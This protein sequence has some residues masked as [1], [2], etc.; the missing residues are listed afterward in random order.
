LGLPESAVKIALILVPP[1]QAF[2]DNT[3]GS[4]GCFRPNH[5]VIMA[6]AAKPGKIILN[7]KLADQAFA[8]TTMA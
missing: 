1:N 5:V 4:A 7:E 3:M 8:L 6:F 2:H